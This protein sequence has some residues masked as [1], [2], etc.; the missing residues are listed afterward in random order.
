MASFPSDF[1][2]LTAAHSK[3]ILTRFLP[4][5][6]VSCA[7]GGGGKECAPVRNV[8]PS[9]SAIGLTNKDRASIR[10]KSLWVCDRM[11][12]GGVNDC[13][14]NGD[15]IDQG[16]SALPSWPPLNAYQTQTRI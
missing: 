5:M 14:G 4:A 7:G 11:V 15:A 2:L 12:C 8:T 3:N 9:N 1:L 6:R 16:G 10:M 13:V